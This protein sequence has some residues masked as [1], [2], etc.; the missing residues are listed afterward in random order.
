MQYVLSTSY[1][2]VRLKLYRP[3]LHYLT[4]SRQEQ[5]SSRNFSLYAAESINAAQ[6][7]LHLN[8]E[9]LESGTQAVVNWTT[10]NMV[11]SSILTLLY[12]VLDSG[13]SQRAEIMFEDILIGR[14]LID[15]LARY[16]FAAN[17]ARTFLTVS[18]GAK[19]LK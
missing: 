19:T 14:R 9:L 5:S 15:N 4:S 18:L 17:R 13:D 7:I 11:L 12:V 10:T 6:S 3:F 8:Q 16:G 1:S 2:L